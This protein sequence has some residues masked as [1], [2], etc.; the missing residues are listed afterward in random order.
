MSYAQL[1]ESVDE[2]A[3]ANTV[4]TQAALDSLASST[5]AQELAATYAESSEQSSVAAT[6]SEQNALTSKNAAAA[7]AAAAL[8]SQNAAGVS[9]TA[10]VDSAGDSANRAEIAAG[11]ANRAAA[12]AD[13]AQLSAGVYATT[14]LGLAATAVDRYFSVPSADSNEYLILYKNNAGVAEWISEYPSATPVKAALDQVARVTTRTAA[15]RRLP[16][17][18]LGVKYAVIASTKYLYYIN[19]AG[20]TFDNNAKPNYVAALQ[21]TIPPDALTAILASKPRRIPRG[22]L[23]VKTAMAVGGKYVW[24]ALD[25]GTHINKSQATSQGPGSVISDVSIGQSLSLGAYGHI[26]T[27]TPGGALSGKV[28]NGKPSRFANNLLML[29]NRGVRVFPYGADFSAP[30]VDDFTGLGPMYEKVDG[31]LGETIWSGYARAL[32]AHLTNAGEASYRLLPIAAGLGNSRYAVLKKGTTVWTAA[33]NAITAAQYL[34]ELRGWS[35]RVGDLELIHGE[36]ETA[37]S[38]ADYKGF[39]LEWLTD[40][41]ADTTAITGQTARSIRCTYPQM[42]TGGTACEGVINAQVELHETNPD[43]CLY[44]PKYQF[45]YYDGS[46][47]I[48]EGYVKTGE[49][50]ARAKRFLLQNKKWDCLRPISAVLAGSVV[51][52]T[53]NNLVAGNADTPG[54]IGAL[55]FDT[56]AA[57]YQSGKCGFYLFGGGGVTVVSAALVGTN[58]VA[59]TLSGAPTAGAVLKYAMGEVFAGAVRDTDT[60]DKSSFDNSILY[61]YSI[62]KSFNI[63]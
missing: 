27:T 14:A 62:A 52:L 56:T 23:G 8:V 55:A 63:N 34:C 19:D 53:Y 9:A 31:S 4:L 26:D 7:S 36:S 24:Y 12:A 60:R 35:Y 33:M 25:D 46:H 51:T 32:Y 21:M 2:L 5:I 20:L 18:P 44:T 49:L 15:V 40:F 38:Q 39:M 41:R 61:N 42:N 22:P 45:K 47:M 10:S 58:Q 30:A 59:V 50:R 28:F 13:A 54:P 16:R 1:A 3:V 43:F 11:E 48:A 17:G 57:L 37:T 6:T 29:L